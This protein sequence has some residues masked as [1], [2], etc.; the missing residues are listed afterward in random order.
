MI[1]SV[2]ILCQTAFPFLYAN[3]FNKEFFFVLFGH[4]GFVSA[5]TVAPLEAFLQ[6]KPFPPMVSI[7]G[8]FFN[9]GAI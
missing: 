6:R 8:D 3:S 5:S 4:G 2:S 9:R 7:P 1:G